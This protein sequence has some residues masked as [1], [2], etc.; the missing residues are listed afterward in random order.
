MHIVVNHLT[1]MEVPRIC[2]AG[3]DPLT[4]R[5]VRPVTRLTDRLTRTMLGTFS[6]GALVDI[7]RATPVPQAPDPP[8]ATTRDS[9]AQ[10]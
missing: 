6:L 8:Q 2:V 3:I 4:G 10:L 5:H 7:G 1:R 9:S